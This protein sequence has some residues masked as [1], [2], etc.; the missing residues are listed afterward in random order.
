MPLLLLILFQYHHY[1][2]YQHYQSGY[3]LDFLL[4]NPHGFVAGNA[5]EDEH[6]QGSD[7]EEEHR[8]CSF[9]RIAGTEGIKFHHLKRHARHE[10]HEKAH[11]ERSLLFDELNY[12]QIL[13]RQF[14]SHA[15]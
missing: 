14:N 4:I 1:T 8:E 13:L 10:R 7:C 6:R 5:E 2:H 9:Y 11:S 12:L 3:Y 15:V